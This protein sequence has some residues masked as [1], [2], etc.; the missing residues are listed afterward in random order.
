MSDMFGTI[1][2]RYL[3]SNRVKCSGPVASS[4]CV[5]ST[6]AIAGAAPFGTELEGLLRTSESARLCEGSVL[7]THGRRIRVS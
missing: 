6:R 7:G 1:A 5:E 4:L 2:H 3:A